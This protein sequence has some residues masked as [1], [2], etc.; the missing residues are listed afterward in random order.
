MKQMVKD[1]EKKYIEK[2]G[3]YIYT[4]ISR[5]W[6]SYR[7]GRVKKKREQLDANVYV[8]SSPSEKHDVTDKE[9]GGGKKRRRNEKRKNMKEEKKRQIEKQRERETRHRENYYENS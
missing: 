1:K 7:N 3:K 8:R 9:G 6:I 2:N 4:H 5:A